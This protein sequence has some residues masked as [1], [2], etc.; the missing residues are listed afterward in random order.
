MDSYSKEIKLASL[1]LCQA[2]TSAVLFSIYRHWVYNWFSWNIFL[3]GGAVGLSILL[4]EASKKRR[5]VAFAII[6]IAWLIFFPNAPYMV[7]DIMHISA[8]GFYGASYDIS[9]WIGLFYITSCVLL[10]ILAGL[11]ALDNAV[12]AMSHKLTAVLTVI[13]ASLL[14]GYAMYIGRF[15]RFNS[16]NLINPITLLNYL[17][18]DFN[19]FAAQFSL[20][21]ACFVAGSYG[22]YVFFTRPTKLKRGTP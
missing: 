22:V 20:L 9:A 16:W 3:A 12:K 7:T 4:C 15:L 13:A 1:C 8:L 14:S 17:V 21:A 6:F 2:A 19:L 11:F 10:G 18:H 5:K